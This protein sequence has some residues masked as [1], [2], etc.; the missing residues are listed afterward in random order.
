[1]SEYHNNFTFAVGQNFLLQ[2]NVTNMKKFI[3][4]ICMP[5]KLLTFSTGK[6]PGY[7]SIPV[8]FLIAHGLA[9]PSNAQGD[10]FGMTGGC[11]SYG[12]GTIFKI[13]PGSS[14][15]SIVHEFPSEH[16]E[17]S[18]SNL[19]LAS[20]GKLYGTAAGGNKSNG[21][22]YEIDPET[23]IY[24]KK[25]EFDSDYSDGILSSS[26]VQADNGKLYGTSSCWGTN[27]PGGVFEYDPVTNIFTKKYEFD[28]T[29]SGGPPH[30]TKASN[31]KLYGVK[32]PE[33]G[34]SSGGAIFE[35]DPDSNTYTRKFVF[36]DYYNSGYIFL[37]AMTLA[38]NG[39]LYGANPWGGNNR[40]GFIYEYDP[41][42]N[43][44]T[45]KQE[46]DDIDGYFPVGS[47][48]SV[49]N[50]KFYG[51]TA[52]GGVHD[53][54]GIYEYDPL[55]N[56]RVSLSAFDSS[57]SWVYGF[58]QTD[59]GKLYGVTNGNYNSD[60][61][62]IVEYD[63][64]MGILSRKFDFNGLNGSPYL[65]SALVQVPNGKLIGTT[66]KG[67]SNDNGVIFEY[68]PATNSFAKKIDFG[69]S[70]GCFP[71][72]T[73]MQASNGKLYGTTE[74]GGNYNSGVLFEYDPVTYVYAKKADFGGNM[75]AFPTGAMV[76]HGNGKLYGMT[77]LG[78][79]YNNLYSDNITGIGVIFEYDPVTSAFAKKI[80]FDYA[81]TN[82]VHPSGSLMRAY[83]GKLYGMTPEG[84]KYNSG[85][86]FEYDPW[87]NNFTKVFDFDGN[88]S[89]GH[90]NGGLTQAFNGKL[91]G[92]TT[93]SGGNDGSTI[94]EYDP[95][96]HVYTKR[97]HFND[98]SSECLQNPYGNLLQ[99]SNGKLYGMTAFACFDSYSG[100]LFEYDPKTN[101]LVKKIEFEGVNGAHPYGSLIQAS[102]GKLYGM[103]SYG[104]SNNRGIVFEFDPESD[105]YTI[106]ENLSSM[107]GCY[108]RGDFI[109]VLSAADLNQPS[110][111][112]EIFP[113][114]ADDLVNIRLHG[115]GGKNVEL[116]I[117][118]VLGMVAWQRQEG[119]IA[120]PNLVVLVNLSGYPAG[121][122]WIGVQSEGKILAKKPL[123]LISANK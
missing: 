119:V 35:Y 121:M 21:V 8:L 102:N 18:P 99:V 60:L 67:G 104:G 105:D 39:K 14:D 68:N 61:G 69:T 19:T 52:Q 90:P 64:E 118:D 4:L 20:N 22:I 62:A 40:L 95:E 24:T 27:Y 54:G 56:V 72:G 122:Y 116:V 2:F 6:L 30:M 48:L 117:Y 71:G 28:N 41:A 94:F 47:F 100:G 73:L 29:N 101:K 110:Q 91:Y 12:N 15:F 79:K 17:V 58:M 23:G 55:T 112:I 16:P 88:V 87:T 109:E 1:M 38:P 89:G 59:N 74:R 31:G 45:I 75:G 98:G 108:P 92:T 80:D 115:F 93:Y 11:G 106:L 36:E 85:V 44:F 7:F 81:D 9:V 63:I 43:T 51:V 37:G 25:Y 53:Y 13:R 120:K 57:V 49:A 5:N 113:N 84:G 65:N 97:I 77:T 96:K 83:N 42:A 46:F 10:L 82:G 76:Q 33:C 70:D 86:I 26:L 34:C 114:P 32:G 111:D 103:T 50:G 3:L 66:S 123:V 78:G 107:S